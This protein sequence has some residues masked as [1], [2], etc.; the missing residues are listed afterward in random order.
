MWTTEY[1]FDTFG[2]LQRLVYPDG[3]ELTYAFD[4]GGNLRD[5]QS[6]KQRICFDVAALSRAA[7]AHDLRT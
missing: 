2:R 5:D 6:I 7:L 3:E 4:T 1:L